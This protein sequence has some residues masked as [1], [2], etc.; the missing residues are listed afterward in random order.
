MS[1]LGNRQM[2]VYV[3]WNYLEISDLFAYGE[4]L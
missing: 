4:G 1:N 2:E 3:L